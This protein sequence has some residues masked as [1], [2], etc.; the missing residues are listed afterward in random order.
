MPRALFS[1]KQVKH[2]LPLNRTLYFALIHSHFSYG[3]V[4]WGN[5]DQKI[6]RPAIYRKLDNQSDSEISLKYKPKS[7]VILAPQS[8]NWLNLII[9]LKHHTHIVIKG[10]ISCMK[11]RLTTKIGRPGKGPKNRSLSPTRRHLQFT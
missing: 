11:H 9:I 4:A 3:I 8:G 7:T 6:M 1:I 10:V 2:I 5:A